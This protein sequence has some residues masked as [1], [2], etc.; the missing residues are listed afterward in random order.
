MKFIFFFLKPFADQMHGKLEE[1]IE[2]QKEVI[3]TLVTAYE[4]RAAKAEME[5]KSLKVK[6]N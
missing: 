2:S 5:T 4:Q 1:E 6:T 3:R